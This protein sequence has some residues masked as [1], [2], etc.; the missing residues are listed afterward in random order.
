VKIAKPTSFSAFKIC[1]ISSSSGGVVRSEE[2]LH[3]DAADVVGAG[4]SRQ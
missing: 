4:T 3:R 2:H 1:L